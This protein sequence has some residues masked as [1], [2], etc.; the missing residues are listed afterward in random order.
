MLRNICHKSRITAGFGVLHNFITFVPNNLKIRPMGLPRNK[1]AR[2]KRSGLRDTHIDESKKYSRAGDAFNKAKKLY[3]A[4]SATVYAING[5]YY[6]G[7]KS[8]DAY[9]KGLVATDYR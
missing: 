7:K 9:M 3:S 2:S 4:A 5:S 8:S 6:P 1:K